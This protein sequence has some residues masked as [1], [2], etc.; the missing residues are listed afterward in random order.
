MINRHNLLSMIPS[1]INNTYSMHITHLCIIGHDHTLFESHEL[2]LKSIKK[3]IKIHPKLTS[4]I[5]E[6]TKRYEGQFRLRNQLQTLL[7]VETNKK[8]YV[9]PTVHDRACRFCFDTNFDNE[10]GENDDDDD[11]DDR[12]SSNQRNR[13]FCGIPL[14]QLKKQRKSNVFS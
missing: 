5:L 10:D 1:H 2:F 11:D 7:E 9:Y 13:T 4:L 12:S 3:L 6:F 8:V 14:F